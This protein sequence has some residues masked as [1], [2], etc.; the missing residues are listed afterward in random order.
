MSRDG[1]RDVTLAD[2]DEPGTGDGAADAP[3]DHHRARHDVAPD[4]PAAVAAPR[5]SRAGPRR[6]RWWVLV[7]LALVGLLGGVLVVDGV[8]SRRQIE[9]L[10]GTPGVLEP[11]DSPL[12]EVWNEPGGWFHPAVHGPD[13]MVNQFHADGVVRL[14]GTDVVTGE[15][16]WDVTVPGSPPEE[17]ISCT[18]LTPEAPDVSTH[19]LCRLEVPVGPGV[20]LPRHGP[21]GEPRLLVLD[22]RTGDTVADRALDH[23]FGAIAALDADVV[24]A[25]VRP[26]G[27]VRLQRQ[28]PVSGEVRWTRDGDHA[29]V[30]AGAGIGPRAPETE[31]QQGVVVV[32]GALGMAV[33]ADGEVLGQWRAPSGELLDPDAR[34]VTVTV[35]ADGRF[36]VG[37]DVQPGDGTYGTVFTTDASDGFP[38]DGPVLE[39]VVDDGSADELLLTVDRGAGEIVALDRRT[40]DPVWRAEARP[41]AESLVVDHRLITEAGRAVVALDTRTGARL[42]DR[43][44]DADGIQLLTDGRVVVVPTET[45]SSTPSVLTAADL[46]DGRVR[47]TAEGPAGVM[48]FYAIGGRLIALQQEAMIRLR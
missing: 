42:W 44:V 43:P 14:V 30:G 33:S 20:E 26:D 47:W 27:R 11:V 9:R 13:L 32:E 12:E 25:T 28:D 17:S 21:R 7:A 23:G 48:G 18:P 46:A 45:Q 8:R 4:D 36:V 39:P 34:A 22:A 41:N 16:L 2:D 15:E 6:R 29:L 40:G 37:S 1:M 5:R 24:V 19:V 10:A 35:L 3:G 31:V 38:I